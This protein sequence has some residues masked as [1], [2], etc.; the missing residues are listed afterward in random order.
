MPAVPAAQNSLELVADADTQLLEL[1]CYPLAE[2][3]AGEA[4]QAQVADG[5]KDIAAA[6]LAAHDS[7]ELAAA[8]GSGHDGYKKWVNSVGKAQGRKG[9]RLFMPMRIAFTGRMQVRCGGG[10]G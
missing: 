3:L 4:G 6:V 5:F 10:G 7:G 8:L 1:L 2:T 9:K